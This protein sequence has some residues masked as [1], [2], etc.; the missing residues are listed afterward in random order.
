MPI[1][2]DRGPKYFA[3]QLSENISETPE[4]YLICRN[5]VIGRSGF[6]TYKVG[7]ITDPD[8]LLGDRAPHEEVE[9]WRDPAEVFSPRTLAS[10]EGKSVT[11]THPDSLLTPDSEREHFVG[12]V[13]N[14]RKGTE[15]LENGDWPILAD[16]VVKV[17]EAIDAINAGVREL[18]CGYAYI[19]AREG[20]R[21]EQRQITGNHVAI[22]RKGRAGDEARIYD[23]APAKETFN[24]SIWNKLFGSGFAIAKDAKPEEIAAISRAIAFDESSEGTERTERTETHGPKSLVGKRLVIVGKDSKGNDLY[25]AVA[26]DAEEEMDAKAKHRK[27]LHDALDRSLD[28]AEKQEEEKTEEEDAAMDALKKMFGAKDAEEADDNKEEMEEKEEKERE[29]GEDSSIVAPEPVLPAGDRPKSAFDAQ[30]AMDM[31]TALKPFIAKANNKSLNAAFDTAF[32]GIKAVLKPSKDGK[33]G[34]G[35]FARAASKGKDELQAEEESPAQKSAREFDAKMAD[36]MKKS[37]E[38][39][40]AATRR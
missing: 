22:V 11:F 13:Q 16:I 38:R 35:A 19:L 30:A 39:S 40:H 12:H 20:Y 29:E 21:F 33:G 15:A 32:N 37:R 36:I 27:S 26:L 24:M 18:S 5:S 6:Q 23:A 31:L 7:D 10:F 8:G 1:A 25:A 9:L 28:A 4:G 3:S 14:V 34:Y 2:L 17:R